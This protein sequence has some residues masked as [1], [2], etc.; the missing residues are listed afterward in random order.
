MR[1]RSCPR[2][3]E[4]PLGRVDPVN[5]G[6]CAPFDD[7]FGEGAIAAADVDPT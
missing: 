5:L 2:V 3:L 4:L 7:Q 1:V 6:W